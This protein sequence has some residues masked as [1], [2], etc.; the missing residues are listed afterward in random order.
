M[1]ATSKPHRSN[2][3][4]GRES[5]I[6]ETISVILVAL[7]KAVALVAW[8]SLSFPMIGIPTFASVCIGV[9]VGPVFGL[10]FA[11]LSGLA[12]AAWSQ[13]SPRSFQLWVT[14]RIRTRW[15]TWS[16]YRNPWAAICILHGLSA[17]LDDQT[18]VP[19]LRSVTIGIT[20]DVIEVA[21]L[22]GQSVTDWQNKSAALA[23]ALR[24]LRV[25][26]RSVKP[27]TIRLTA[28]HGDPLATPAR[29]PR[30]LTE[31]T[32]D[33]SSVR[34]GVTD[35]GRW[36]RLSVLGQHILI[37]GATGSG[38]G[39]V[40]WSIIAALAPGVRAGSVRLL[41]VDPKGG[42]EFGR[43]QKLF[44]GFAHDNADNTVAL[45]R[46][47]T[48][49]MQKR[50]Q[51][52]RGYTRLHVPTV[53]EPLIVLMIDEIASLTAYIGDRKTRAEVEQ[54]LGLLLSQGRAVGVSVIAA[55]QDPSKDVLPIRQLFSIRVGLRMTESTQT[56]MVLGAA[57]REAGAV[58]D[59]IPTTTP[60]VGYVCVDGTA[61]P[62]RV[63]AFHVTDPDI[64]Y[65][66]EHFA[67]HWRSVDPSDE[68]ASRR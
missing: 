47:V 58:C 8:W 41:V 54:L 19:A 17:K 26:V 68:G 13:L 22:R 38:K 59:D 14:Q 35:A 64:D 53:A 28:H 2:N 6:D 48:I 31:T 40:L 33:P 16:I 4:R 12:L 46:A 32:V 50:A 65:L 45:L 51:R 56:T 27:G 67:P 7:A 11:V 44:T 61:E 5:D 24:A 36:W 1:A 29:L 55:V 9:C 15:R 25:T 49:V 21:I 30:P 60:G 18:L 34:V 10:A 52:L 20:T 42:M 43:G 57:A 23:E 3:S 66:S 62:V 37:G 39:S 63:R